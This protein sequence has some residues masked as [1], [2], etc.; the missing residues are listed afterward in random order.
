M[1][2]QN[3][4]L[5]LRGLDDEQLVEQIRDDLYDGLKDELEEGVR[6][7]LERG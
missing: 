4:E 5:D 6:I 2:E 7:L 3:E 1:S